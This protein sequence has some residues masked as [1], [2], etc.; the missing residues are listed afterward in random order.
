MICLFT[1]LMGH[2]T[3]FF[4]VFNELMKAHMND[5]QIL[6][7]VAKSQEFE[8]IKVCVCVCVFVCLCV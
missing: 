6:G 3:F 4:E 2:V 1:H 8:Q 7:M 5:A